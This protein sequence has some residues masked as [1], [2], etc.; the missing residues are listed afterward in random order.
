MGFIFAQIASMF[1]L[2]TFIFYFW[3]MDCPLFPQRVRL[4]QQSLSDYLCSDVTDQVKYR[5][6]FLPL[7][8]QNI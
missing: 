8:A 4:C 7:K 5:G 3:V 2:K 1:C 6:N